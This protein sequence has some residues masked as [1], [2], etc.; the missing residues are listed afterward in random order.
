MEFDLE[1]G[2]IG[3]LENHCSRIEHIEHIITLY[4]LYVRDLILFLY[5]Q[6]Y[7]SMAIRKPKPCTRTTQARPAPCGFPASEHIGFLYVRGGAW[8]RTYRVPI[9]SGGPGGEHLGFLVRPLGAHKGL[10]EEPLSRAF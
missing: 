6:S 4:S 7:N 3:K 9:F 10:Y 8:R 5:S 1:V 2:L